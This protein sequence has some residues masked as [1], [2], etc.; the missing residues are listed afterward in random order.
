MRIAVVGSRNWSDPDRIRRYI[1]ALPPDTVVVSGGAIGADRVAAAA[2]RARGLPVEIF[3]A[4]WRENGRS[5]WFIRNDEMIRAVDEVVA[6][7]DGSSKETFDSIA[8][9]HRYGKPCM[10]ITAGR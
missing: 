9:A 2:A 1:D 8:R 4:K 5:A 7:W 10:V 3:W 6:F